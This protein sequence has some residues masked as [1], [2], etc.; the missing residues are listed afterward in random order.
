[1]FNMKIEDWFN[2]N[3][4]NVLEVSHVMSNGQK[5]S[6]GNVSK[7]YYAYCDTVQSVIVACFQNVI[8][9]PE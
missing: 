8:S 5:N 4:I 2:K 1:M 6:N 7:Q 3:L 9:Y